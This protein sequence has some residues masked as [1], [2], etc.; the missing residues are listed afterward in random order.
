MTALLLIGG[1]VLLVAGG[2]VL[3]RGASTMARSFGLS[4]LVIGL[5]VVSFATSA[6]ELAVTARASLAGSPGLAVGNVVG[7]NIANILLVIGVAGLILPLAVRLPVVRRDVPVMIVLS[8]LM[9]GLSLQGDGVSRLDGG[10]LLALLIGYV[11]WAVIRSRQAQSATEGKGRLTH[12]PGP[13]GGRPVLLALLLVVVGVAM[14]VL[15]AQW[16]V[17]AATEIALALGMSEMVVGLTIV[18][19]GTSLPELAT[20]VIA[21][22]RGNVEMAVGNA[23]GS[24]IF[25]IG[26]VM[27]LAAVI[28]PGG[29]PV[30]ASALRFDLPVMVAVAVALLPIAFT[31]FTIKRW[32]AGLF[33]AYYT[34][35]VV[36]LLLNSA[37]HAVLDQFSS[38]M[39]LFVLPLTG[40]TLA[41][42]ATYEI[43]LRRGR[44]QPLLDD[45]AGEDGAER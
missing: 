17:D 3:V 37:Q 12:A 32:E 22:I 44:G 29:V 21:A 38:V 5:T 36:F 11:A 33:L 20:S 23:V 8:L 28:T 18:A 24:C 2:E 31:G 15:G 4:P 42:L 6:P 30:E 13:G 35:Y 43:G 40:L 7:S 27:G 9:W 26:A 45:G 41:L 16:L 14:L 10:V 1:F 25:N 19:V 34:A 39:L